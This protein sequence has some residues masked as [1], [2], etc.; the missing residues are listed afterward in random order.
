MVLPTDP[1]ETIT[2]ILTEW[3]QAQADISAA[4]VVGSQA[5]PV[6]VADEWSD[7]DVVMFVT[8]PEVYLTG[9]DWIE[10]FGNP[11][12]SFTEPTAVG[13]QK[14]LRALYDN[15]KDVDFSLFST[16]ALEHMASAG[17]PPE[18]QA[19]MVRGVKVLFDKTGYLK[20]FQNETRAHSPKQLKPTQATFD[21][22]INN[23][24][25]HA[26]LTAKKLRRG[27]LWTAK[28]CHDGYMKALLLRVTEW[29]AH[30]VMGGHPDTWHKGRF[31]ERWADA[32]IVKE[33]AI[34]FSHYD[35]ADIWRGLVRAMQ[36]FRWVTR[37]V[38]DSLALS[39]PQGAADYVTN[40]VQKLRDE[41]A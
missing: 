28:I 39:Y 3:G 2:N 16:A 29:H 19:V 1:Y 33:L 25:Y 5:R 23:Y 36:L 11:I 27:E 21:E 18:M 17:I 12:L 4:I 26:L 32:R 37:E 13:G 6:M 41:A 15:G 7:L 20:P 22:F 38:A 40:Q 10:T 31:L 30:F 35:E 9:R 34:A 8:A 24:Y 14:E